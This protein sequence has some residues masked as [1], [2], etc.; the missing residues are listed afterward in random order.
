MKEKYKGIITKVIDG[1]TVEATIYY[2]LLDNKH[3]VED[4]KFRLY[5]I[6]TPEIRGEEKEEG[7]KVKEHLEDMLLDKEVEI[8]V[9]HHDKYGGRWDAEIYYDGKII[10][11]YLVEK[12]M[13]KK[14]DYEGGKKK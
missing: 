12:G 8:Y 5:G 11:K 9:L 4:V 14:V 3:T 2:E 6:N 7:L 10:N 13:A 1:D